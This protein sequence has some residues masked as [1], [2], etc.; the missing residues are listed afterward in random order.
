MKY[1]CKKCGAEYKTGM[2]GMSDYSFTGHEK[3]LSCGASC[4]GDIP[5]RETVAQWEKRT[6]HKYSDTA[7]VY[8]KDDY[9][10][11][12]ELLPYCDAEWYEQ[13]MLHGYDYIVVATET[14]A[15]PDNWRP[16]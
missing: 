2:G 7:P 6:G 14:G 11:T 10:T 13:G 4:F 3:C 12:W 9:D 5:Y 15:P 8:A 1:Y 16:E